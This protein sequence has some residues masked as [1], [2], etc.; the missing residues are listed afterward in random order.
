MTPAKKAELIAKHAAARRRLRA[1]GREESLGN[2]LG[3]AGGSKRDIVALWTESDPDTA[4]VPMTDAEAHFR[5]TFSDYLA[6]ATRFNAI[7]GIQVQ[8]AYTPMPGRTPP[9]LT[10]RY[11]LSPT[12]PWYKDLEEAVATAYQAHMQAWDALEGRQE[13]ARQEPEPALEPEPEPEPAFTLENL[14]RYY[15]NMRTSPWPNG[16]KLPVEVLPLLDALWKD[17][18][19]QAAKAERAKYATMNSHTGGGASLDA[20][21][22][23]VEDQR[24]AAALMCH[25]I[26]GD[27]ARLRQRARDEG[28]PVPA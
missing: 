4:P 14:R 18:D 23:P 19:A 7:S 16:V 26:E 2:V 11:A 6:A 8:Y 25:R 24:S 13:A 15:M 21:L 28:Q 5:K 3:I 10:R 27:R 20:A 9:P 12:H 1:E 22:K 17:Y